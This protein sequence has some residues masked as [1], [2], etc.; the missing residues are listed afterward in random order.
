MGRATAPPVPL[1]ARKPRPHW[2]QAFAVAGVRSSVPHA[3]QRVAEA[4]RANGLGGRELFDL[5]VA[6]GEALSNAVCHGSP[7][8]EFD[9]VTVRVGLLGESV[10][11]EITDR[12]A[13]FGASRL[14]PPDVLDVGGRGIP[15]MRALVDDLHFECHDGGTTVVLVKKIPS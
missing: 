8:A 13:G 14:C 11:V 7:Y 3:R 6:V 5:L 10:V 15:S 2:L 9:E 12:G 1:M 4:A